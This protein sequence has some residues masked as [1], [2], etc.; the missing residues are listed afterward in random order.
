MKEKIKIFNFKVNYIKNKTVFTLY[1]GKDNV[2]AA[3]AIRN[4]LNLNNKFHEM[5]S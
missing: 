3:Q 2:K 1:L 5:R 4:L